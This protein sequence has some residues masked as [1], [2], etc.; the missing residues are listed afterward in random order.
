MTHLT[1]KGYRGSIRFSAQDKVFWGKIED[2]EGLITFE[3]EHAKDFEVHFRNAVDAYLEDC[4]SL[5]LPP[6]Q[7]TQ[8]RKTGHA[9]RPKRNADMGEVTA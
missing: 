3:A 7:P 8:K 2:I 9:V 6:Q 4:R 5:A 1:Y